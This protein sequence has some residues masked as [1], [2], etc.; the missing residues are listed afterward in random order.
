MRARAR[1]EP[2]HWSWRTLSAGRKARGGSACQRW[3]QHWSWRTL[4]AGR[5]ARGGECLSALAAALVV[6]DPFGGA[7]G[8]RGECL[9][10][11]AAALDVVACRPALAA[12]VVAGQDLPTAG[13]TCK[14]P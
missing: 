2:Q 3:P 11:L 5:K 9:S 10:V 7:Q 14:R 4:S 12:E 6:A 13:D 1:Y 8:K